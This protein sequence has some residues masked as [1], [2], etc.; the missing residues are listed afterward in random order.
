MTVTEL[1]PRLRPVKVT[2]LLV[3]NVPGY[4]PKGVDGRDNLPPPR[5]PLISVSGLR[6]TRRT[7]N[8]VALAWD[9]GRKGT[10]GYNVYLEAGPICHATKYHRHTSVWGKTTVTIGA[11]LPATDYAVKVTAINEQKRLV[12]RPP[13]R[14]MIA[15]W[16]D[17][18]KNLPRLV[19]Y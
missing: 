4:V 10:C 19:S 5:A 11:L 7:K 8:S 12:G 18:A 14:A 15:N 13:S 16:I 3:T 1:G 9:A 6:R 17:R 2:K